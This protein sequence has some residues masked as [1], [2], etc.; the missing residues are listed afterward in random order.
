MPFHNSQPALQPFHCRNRWDILCF[1][2]AQ[3]KQIFLC[4]HSSGTRNIT[5]SSKS[6]FEK[7]RVFNP[8][9]KRILKARCLATIDSCV[10][11]MAPLDVPPP[12]RGCIAPF[13]RGFQLQTPQKCCLKWRNCNHSVSAVFS[14][15]SYI[16]KA[17]QQH[18][19][20]DC[21]GQQQFPWLNCYVVCVGD[22][23]LQKQQSNPGGKIVL[24][25]GM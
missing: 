19:N 22:Y 12:Q 4:R 1:H 6:A 24:F 3:M 20:A 5:P 14:P 18:E 10:K 21:I 13:P 23:R 16:S 17:K 9:V 2:T 7:G 15:R 11:M 8:C 25:F